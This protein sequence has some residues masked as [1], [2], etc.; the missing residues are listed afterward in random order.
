MNFLREQKTWIV[1]N[2]STSRTTGENPQRVIE[3]FPKSDSNHAEQNN[4]TDL[5]STDN[6]PDVVDVLKKPIFQNI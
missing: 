5:F 2:S 3:C 6:D 1:I 4:E